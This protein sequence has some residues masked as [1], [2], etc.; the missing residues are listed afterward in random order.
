V[1]GPSSS[2]ARAMEPPPALARER[3]A[4][5]PELRCNWQA[6]DFPLVRILLNFGVAGRQMLWACRR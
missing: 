3:I 4:S 2:N 6:E 5:V 1:R